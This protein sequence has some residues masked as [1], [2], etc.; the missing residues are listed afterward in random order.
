MNNMEKKKEIQANV[1]PN[2]ARWMSLENLPNEK[3][4]PIKKFEH[5]YMVSTY[6]RIKTIDRIV[7]FSDGRVREYRSRIMSIHK[8]NARYYVVSLS[9]PSCRAMKDVHR[10]VAE[11]FIANPQNLPEVN[12][13]DENSLN[14]QVDNLE[15]CTRKYNLN[16]GTHNQRMIEHLRNHPT[17]SKPVIQKNLDG[18]IVAQYPSIREAARTLG[19]IKKDCN[20]LR[21]CKG[22]SRTSHGYKWEYLQ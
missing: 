4:K 2:S 1:I 8:I 11:T 20:I 22:I 7:K 12:H 21:A 18:T 5:F 14:N 15:W 10:L 3:W 6:G 16:Y 19:N 13:K 17:T 9:K